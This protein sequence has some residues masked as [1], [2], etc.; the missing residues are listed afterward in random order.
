MI[1]SVALR[2]SAL[3]LVGAG[4][5]FAGIAEKEKELAE[6]RERIKEISRNLEQIGSQE[7]DL[8]NQLA[9]IERKYGEIARSINELNEQAGLKQDRLREIRSQ[10]SLIRGEIGRLGRELAAQ[11]RSAHAMG[12]QDWLKLVLNQQDPVR[13]SRMMA[14]YNYVNKSRREKLSL[15]KDGMER[16]KALEGQEAAE[17]DILGDLVVRRRSEQKELDAARYER[18][19]LL[20]ELKK[21]SEATGK[22]L[23]RL[24]TDEESIMRLIAEYQR[25]QDEFPEE[26]TPAKPFGDRKGRLA[27]PINGRLVNSFGSKRAGGYWDGVL[28]EAGE[29]SEIRAIARGR[30]I[31][32]DWLRG[33]GLLIILDHGTGYMTLYA[34]NQSLFREVGDWVEEGEVIATVGNSGGRSRSGLYFG[35]RRQGK[36]IDPVN[37]CRKNRDG[38][39]G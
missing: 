23:A 13:F 19:A 37:W 12:R 39:A 22:E 38:R 30:V 11:I 31:F 15:V 33:Y 20:A 28:I 10:I 7:Q 32:S 1:N 8:E 27:W 14:Y 29:G 25:H 24:K 21:D 36:P 18:S 6:T 35:I 4:I 17:A 2:I 34:F 26:A 3:F 5:S 16:L 9:E